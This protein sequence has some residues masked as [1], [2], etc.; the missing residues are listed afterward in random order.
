LARKYAPGVTFLRA[1]FGESSEP[2]A[3]D[4]CR[5]LQT[6][7]LTPQDGREWILGGIYENDF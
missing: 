4:I 5:R 7:M 3:V 1:W 6:K 2:A